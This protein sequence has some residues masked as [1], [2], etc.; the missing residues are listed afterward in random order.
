ETINEFAKDFGLSGLVVCSRSNEYLAA[1]SRLRL[2]AAIGL[3][4]L[5]SEQIN[6]YVENAG[7]TLKALRATLQQDE[8]L[9]NLA[10]T[11]LMLGV[12]SLAY[13]DIPIEYLS[14]QSS[15]IDDRRMHIF[16][17]YVDRMFQRKGKVNQPYTKETT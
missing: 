1:T 13:Q 8:I 3:Q 4:P 11:P 17:R 7:D 16:G 9:R 6:L 14:H 10:Q 15:D 5:T 2:N 12:M